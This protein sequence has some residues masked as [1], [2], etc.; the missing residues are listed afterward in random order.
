MLPSSGWFDDLT[1]PE[2]PLGHDWE[3]TQRLTLGNIFM[4]F[5]DATGVR[6]RAKAPAD[7][8]SLHVACA[9]A[10]TQLLQKHAR[11]LALISMISLTMT[12][13]TSGEVKKSHGLGVLPRQRSASDT[14]I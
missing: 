3:W 14:F 12:D 5:M 13:L 4:S 11:H 2:R 6:G 9:A 1:I 8:L 7:I 10:L